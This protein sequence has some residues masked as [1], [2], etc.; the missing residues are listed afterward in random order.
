M[1]LVGSVGWHVVNMLYPSVACCCII[2]RS[3]GVRLRAAF[4]MLGGVCSFPMSCNNPAQ[5]IMLSGR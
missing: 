3:S 5:I 2:W 1:M 4:R